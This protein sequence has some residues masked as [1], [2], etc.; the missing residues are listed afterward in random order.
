MQYK[1]N[2]QQ[3]HCQQAPFFSSHGTN[4]LLIHSSSQRQIFNEHKI[5]NI[6]S[7]LWLIYLVPDRPNSLHKLYQF[8]APTRIRTAANVRSSGNQ[9]RVSLDLYPLAKH[10]SEDNY[11]LYNSFITHLKQQW[12]RIRE[13]LNAGQC[14]YILN[15]GLYFPLFQVIHLCEIPPK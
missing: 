3:N 11:S 10:D 6:I 13:T 15:L 8:Q 7:R 14:V 12:V 4:I 2:K 1:D 5:K 9:L